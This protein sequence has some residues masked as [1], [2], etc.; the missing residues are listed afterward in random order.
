METWKLV[1]EAPAYEVSTA[2]NV[3]RISNGRILTPVPSNSGYLRVCLRVN[4]ANIHRSIHRLVAKAFLGP[5]ALEVNHKNGNKFDN[6]VANLEYTTR[7][8]NAEHAA[9]N[10][11]YKTGSAV[12]TAKLHESDIPRIWTLRDAG[13]TYKQIGDTFGVTIGCIAFILNGQSWRRESEA[14]GRLNPLPR[15]PS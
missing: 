10:G 14:L 7:K 12:I 11:A 5:S 3:R 4:N 15:R 13:Y 9:T 8:L 6:A 2:G 1:T